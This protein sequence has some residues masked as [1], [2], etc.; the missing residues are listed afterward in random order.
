MHVIRNFGEQLAF[1]CFFSSETPLFFA[2]TRTGLVLETTLCNRTVCSHPEQNLLYI[3][4]RAFWILVYIWEVCSA[5]QWDAPKSAGLW[6]ALVDRMGPILPHDNDRPHNA[7][8]ML[9]KV[10]KLGCEIL[11]HLPYSPDLLPSDY[12]FIK[13]LDNFFF[14]ENS[15]TTSRRQ[16]MLSTSSLNAD[17]WIFTIQE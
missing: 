14:R 6:L 2:C 17:T 8:S 9:Q 7:E 4:E 12:H 13:H 3:S 15:S 1:P 11:P 16:K 5:S 10:N